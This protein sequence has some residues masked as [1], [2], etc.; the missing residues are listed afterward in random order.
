M[1]VK[2][3][4]CVQALRF[5]EPTSLHPGMPPSMVF[6]IDDICRHVV[7]MASEDF[8]IDFAPMLVFTVAESEHCRKEIY[9]DPWI[10]WPHSRCLHTH[11]V[12]TVAEEIVPRTH[13]SACKFFVANEADLR[14]RAAARKPYG[15][16]H[17]AHGAFPQAPVRVGP[18]WIC[19]KI[20]WLVEFLYKPQRKASP[21][22]IGKAWLGLP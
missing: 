21:R 5:N 11:F 14:V 13:L 8:N 20:Q 6:T 12:N 16:L 19:H 17:E 22:R 9:I 4:T 2:L 18:N 1:S 3:V 15:V 10:P 7:R